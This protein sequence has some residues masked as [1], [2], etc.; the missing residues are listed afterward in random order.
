MQ[1]RM[2]I[3]FTCGLL[4]ACGG[5]SGQGVGGSGGQTGGTGGG[6]GGGTGGVQPGIAKGLVVDTQGRPLAGAKV[7]VCSTVYAYSCIDQTTAADG[8]YSMSL[9]PLNSWDA[10]SSLTTVYNGRAYCLDLHPG[11]PDHFGSDVGAIRNFD[12]RLTGL[13][14]GNETMPTYANSYYG[15]ALSVSSG[16]FNSTLDIQFVQVTFAPQGPLVDGTAGT[17]LTKSAANWH[18]LGIGGIPLGRYTVSATY[19]QPGTANRA[20]LVGTTYGAA[21]SPSAVID[22]DPDSSGCSNPTSKIYTVYAP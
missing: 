13:I 4:A 1:L 15:A 14:P 16:D 2:A 12:W 7:A 8:T 17:T 10:T 9:T 3:V 20:L 5:G 18:E 21:Y 11:N 22:F 19:V 6:G